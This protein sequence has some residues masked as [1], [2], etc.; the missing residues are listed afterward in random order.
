[1][2]RRINQIFDK[3]SFLIEKGSKA[4]CVVFI[5][6]MVSIVLYGVFM[7]YVMLSAVAWA[8]EAPI[9]MMI[10]VAFLAGSVGIKYGTHIGVEVFVKRFPKRTMLTIQILSNVLII[11]FLVVLFTQ[12]YTMT[13]YGFKYQT[14]ISLGIS[15]GWAIL[16]VPVGAILMII[17]SCHLILT[18]LDKL[19]TTSVF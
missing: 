14:S 1:M 3:A 7:R 11:F 5:A 13:I 18:C 16:A 10:W 8:E 4:V 17:E 19:F 15:M 2:I 12:G 9:Y 6:V